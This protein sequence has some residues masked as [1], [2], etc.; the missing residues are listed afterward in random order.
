MLPKPSFSILTPC[1][2]FNHAHAGCQRH[3][4]GLS[5]QTGTP[6]SQGVGGPRLKY[7]GVARASP[8]LRL[9]DVRTS[10]TGPPTGPGGAPPCVRV[11]W[12]GCAPLRSSPPYARLPL[13][14]GRS[15][16]SLAHP[17]SA[18]RLAL[19]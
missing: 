6:L 14:S 13:P 8:R 1:R 19:G 3:R 2:R 11:Q 9:T 7:V 18:T 4:K 17:P 10:Q 12:A 15:A 5:G 16:L